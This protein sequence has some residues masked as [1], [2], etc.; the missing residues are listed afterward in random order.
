FAMSRF[1]HGGFSRNELAHIL[2]VQCRIASCM[3]GPEFQA[4]ELIPMLAD[5][6]LSKEDPAWRRDLDQN[7][8]CKKHGGEENQSQGGAYNIDS[9]FDPATYNPGRWLAIELPMQSARRSLARRV[10]FR[11]KVES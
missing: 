10:N 4:E 3:H 8:D 5:S 7:A 6:R 1:V 9:V 2:P 11:K